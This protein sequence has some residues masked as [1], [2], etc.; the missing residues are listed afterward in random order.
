MFSYGSSCNHDC[1]FSNFPNKTLKK[2]AGISCVTI[3]ECE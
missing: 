1:T 3:E 2:Q